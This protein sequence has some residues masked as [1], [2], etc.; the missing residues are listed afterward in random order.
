MLIRI[1]TL[2]LVFACNS[3]SL[4]QWGEPGGPFYQPV[5]GVAVDPSAANVFFARL[6]QGGIAQSKDNGATWQS[7][8]TAGL[9]FSQI[10]VDPFDGQ[11]LY[12]ISRNELHKSVDGGITWARV[13]GTP[14][15]AFFIAIHPQT[16]NLIYL[17]SDRTLSRSI[18]G[19]ATWAELFRTVFPE[20]I[21]SVAIDPA[22]AN[23][24]YL[25]G[26]G[27]GLRRS[28][29]GGTSWAPISNGLTEQSVSHIAFTPGGGPIYAASLSGIYRSADGGA[30]WQQ[31]GISPGLVVDIEV[32]SARP[33]HVL[34][35]HGDRGVLESFDAG[36][37]WTGL[38]AGLDGMFLVS[39][40][41]VT[42]G[43][44]EWLVATARNGFFGLAA[45]ATQWV[46][47][48][49]LLNPAKVSS[50]AFVSDGTALL[51]GTDGEGNYISFDRGV[52][53]RAQP[54]V[55]DGRLVKQLFV[56]AQPTP[57][58]FA[59][60]PER[61]LR[62]DTVGRLWT[63]QATRLPPGVTMNRVHVHPQVQTTFYMGTTAGIYRSF[64]AGSVWAIVGLENENVLAV[65]VDA[66]SPDVIYASTANGAL[67]TST[68]RG[69]TW[70]DVTA[71]LPVGEII[72]VVA[73]PRDGKTVYVLAPKQGIF[74]SS[75]GATSWRLVFGPVGGA[76][77]TRMEFAADGTLYAVSG[78]ELFRSGDGG[79]SFQTLAL[80]GVNANGDDPLALVVT[81]GG[82]VAVA[83]AQQ[84][85]SVANLGEFQGEPVAGVGA[86]PN[87]SSGDDGGGGSLWGLFALISVLSLR[88]F[89]GFYTAR[90][91]C[92]TQV[93]D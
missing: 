59:L 13:S 19:G 74:V 20:T 53:W 67:F 45:G 1:S 73:H 36:N 79:A 16:P 17:V 61:L 35:A 77:V 2:L 22:S 23:T 39:L 58:V 81:N 42:G 85:V 30:S 11:T 48:S 6:N 40:V 63:D 69:G 70:Q 86:P 27:V 29:D 14:G 93:C 68:D 33:D 55:F 18:D 5:G 15:R 87:A 10:A 80:K 50:L 78:G 54:S 49:R 62:S 9:T 64:N 21:N 56:V 8:I 65:T 12:G 52:T 28:T 66:L 72:D 92:I 26:S 83:I 60:T 47:V 71:A 4:A 89:G 34:V 32:D 46:Q 51:A 90:H 75:D 38:N 25:G 43:E 24:L 88:R 91:G 7:F 37:T 3:L 41:P 44:F 82:D 84:G 76:D 31:T 57:A